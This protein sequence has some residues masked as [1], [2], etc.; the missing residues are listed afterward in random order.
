MI[1]ELGRR[2]TIVGVIQSPL[3]RASQRPVEPTIYL[4]M[5]QNYLP[6]MTLIMGTA[7]ADAGLLRPCGAGSRPW[8]AGRCSR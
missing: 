1:D 2:T 5:A 8:R 7:R 3:L 6:R 4:P